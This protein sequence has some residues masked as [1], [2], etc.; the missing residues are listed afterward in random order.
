[1]ESISPVQPEESKTLHVENFSPDLHKRVKSEAASR[2]QT[3][4][5][6]VT[7]ALEQSLVKTPSQETKRRAS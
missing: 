3:L 1:M 6:F 5:E 7:A 2:G 4:R